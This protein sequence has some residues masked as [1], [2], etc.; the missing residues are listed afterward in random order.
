MSYAIHAYFLKQKKERE[1][2]DSII[3]LF[4]NLGRVSSSFSENAF[5][6]NIFL[7][8]TVDNHYSISIFFDDNAKVQADFDFILQENL[9]CK[10]R[11]RFLFAPDPANDF[12]DISVIILDFLEGLDEVI[13][14]SVNQGKIIFNSLK[15]DT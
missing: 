2:F 3:G 13:I 14:Y 11:L 8:L 15:K 6:K 4:G 12:D 1:L 9:E 5:T 7:K 10:S